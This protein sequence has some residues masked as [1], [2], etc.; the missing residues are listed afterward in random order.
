M[1]R[2]LIVLESRHHLLHLRASLEGK[3]SQPR[4]HS[5]YIGPP[6][7][8]KIMSLRRDDFM[9]KRYGKT[10]AQREHHVA[11][12]SRKRCIK[13]HFQGI[14]H[15]YVKR[16]WI[17]C[18]STRTWSRWRR[19]YQDGWVRGQF[20]HYD[21]VRDRMRPVVSCQLVVVVIPSSLQ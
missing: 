18:I 21:H 5:M 3:W 7:N 6:L 15:R 14:H 13:R 17:S 16:S 1:Q 11:H 12:N 9:A 10:T 2:V 19:L 8:S 20:H 4:R